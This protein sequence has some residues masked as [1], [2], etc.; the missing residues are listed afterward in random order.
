MKKALALLALL[1]LVAPA[2][3]QNE[4][5]DMDGLPDSWEQE[6]FGN[7]DQNGTADNDMDGLNN[8]A[9]YANGTDPNNADT[10]GDGVNDGAEVAAGSDP[11]KAPEHAPTDTEEKGGSKTVVWL[12]VI[13]ALAGLLYAYGRLK[14]TE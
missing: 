11:N 1:M 10:D 8:T 6:H 3:A 14:K 5:T 2:M 13:V 9:E 12:I 4:D 7:L